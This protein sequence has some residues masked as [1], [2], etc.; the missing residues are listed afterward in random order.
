MS[1]LLCLFHIGLERKV[2][3]KQ[4]DRLVSRE[5]AWIIALTTVASRKNFGAAESLGWKNWL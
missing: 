5:S 2:R 3:A 4:L 1:V